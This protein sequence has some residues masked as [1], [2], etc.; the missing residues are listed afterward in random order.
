MESASGTSL[1]TASVNRQRT[2]TTCYGKEREREMIGMER[3]IALYTSNKIT[4]NNRRPSNF[5]KNNVKL[6]SGVRKSR[7]LNENSDENRRVKETFIYVHAF[8]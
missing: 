6:P 4:K 3:K 7:Y 5:Q 2:K 8:S 1:I